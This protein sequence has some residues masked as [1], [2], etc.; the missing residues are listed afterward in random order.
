MPTWSR[1]TPSVAFL[2][3][4]L[5]LNGWMCIN[6]SPWVWIPSSSACASVGAGWYS[7]AASPALSTVVEVLGVVVLVVVVSPDEVD[8]GV[9][10]VVVVDAVVVLA[11]ALASSCVTHV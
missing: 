5:S 4:E 8:G 6:P 3:A 10:V 2:P 1:N 9:V 11:A 7:P